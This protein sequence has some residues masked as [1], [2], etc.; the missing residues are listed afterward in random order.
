MAQLTPANAAAKAS[1]VA[2]GR[3]EARNTSLITIA[4]GVTARLSANAPAG[5]LLHL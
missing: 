3:L 2:F 5:E 4:A 1:A